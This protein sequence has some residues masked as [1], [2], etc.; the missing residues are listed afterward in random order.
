MDPRQHSDVDVSGL[1]EAWSRGDIE[2]RDRL[3]AV[4][5]QELRRR[6]AAHLRR[7]RVG[8]TL[9]P[10]ALV[11]ETYLRLVKPDRVRLAEPRTVLRRRLADDAP[12]PRRPR[13]G[14][15]HDKRSGRWA[16][17]TLDEGVASSRPARSKC[18]TSITRS[19]NSRRSIPEKVRL[20]S[21][22]FSVGYRSKR[23]GTS[24]A[25]P[26]PQWKGSG[27]R[28]GRGSMRV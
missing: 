20:P 22:A 10:T 18:W 15:Q 2:A 27:R 12:H 26:L 14:P 3:M 8:H 9:Q 25:F 28:R 24:L 23:P 1:L 11:H 13:P 6:A 19:S 16:R 17:V 4:V 21:C 7:E 5:Y